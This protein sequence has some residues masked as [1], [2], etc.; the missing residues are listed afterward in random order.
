MSNSINIGPLSARIALGL[1]FLYAGCVKI[2]DPLEFAIALKGYRFFNPSLI[3]YMAIYVPWMEFVC[4]AALLFN[5]TRF[6]ASL[7][8]TI[9]GV[10]FFCVIASAWLRGLEVDCGC[11]GGRGVVSYSI[12]F[13]LGRSILLL[14]VS[15]YLLVFE[16][17]C[18]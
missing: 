4:G 15:V 16:T 6:G 1:I 12:L 9:F 10:C 5:R 3:P 7:L 8:A 18:K 14:G 11:L 13:A 17:I 2:S